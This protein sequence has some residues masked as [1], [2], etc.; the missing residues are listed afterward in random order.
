MSD[1]IARTELS[2]VLLFCPLSLLIFSRSFKRVSRERRQAAS[3][4][5]L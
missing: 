5:Q 1:H 3:L 2:S 4:L